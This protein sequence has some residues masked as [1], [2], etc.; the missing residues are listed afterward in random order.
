MDSV[1]LKVASTD[2]VYLIE[3]SEHPDIK[4]SLEFR[5]L[6]LWVPVEVVP[7][8]VVEITRSTFLSFY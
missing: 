4:S 5:Q 1:G 8:R 7:P 6:S 2:I 3:I